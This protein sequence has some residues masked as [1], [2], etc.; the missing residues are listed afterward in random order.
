M[1]Q[2]DEHKD[3]TIL[4]FKYKTMY[5][6]NK[7]LWGRVDIHVPGSSRTLLSFWHQENPRSLFGG[8]NV[9]AGRRD[10]GRDAGLW[11]DRRH[12]GGQNSVATVIRGSD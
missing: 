11:T 4:S 2:Q 7:V 12:F 1:W 6:I 9:S 3:R 8:G 10:G 5:K